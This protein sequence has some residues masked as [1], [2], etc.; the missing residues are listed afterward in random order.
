[1]I[2]KRSY[3]RTLSWLSN[4]RF[5][6]YDM[7]E[8]IEHQRL[9]KPRDTFTEVLNRFE[10]ISDIS[11]YEW[12]DL[13]HEN[14][15]FIAPV[16]PYKEDSSYSDSILTRRDD[17][18]LDRDTY[19]EYIHTSRNGDITYK[20]YKGAQILFIG[21]DYHSLAGTRLKDLYKTLT[22]A[23]PNVLFVQQKPDRFL[24][25]M[26]Y[27][28]TK[29]KKNDIFI[30]DYGKEQI[31]VEFDI[32]TYINQLVIEGHQLFASHESYN[33][34][35]RDLNKAG[36]FVQKRLKDESEE[37][38]QLRVEEM[39]EYGIMDTRER[40]SADSMTAIG[41][42]ASSHQKP[43]ILADIPDYLHRKNIAR[44][45]GVSEMRELLKEGCSDVILDPKIYPQ[46]PYFGAVHRC[47][48]IM[49]HYGDR[50]MASLL[51]SVINRNPEIGTIAVLC[52]YGQTKSIPTYMDF[53]EATLY[54]NLSVS[55]TKTHKYFGK[56]DSIHSMVEKQVILDHLYLH[57]NECA[58][59]YIQEQEKAG[60]VP[61]GVTQEPIFKT[62][63]YLINHELKESPNPVDYD[64][65][66]FKHLY[67]MLF[68]N[69]VNQLRQDSYAG[70]R[71]QLENEL[72][73]RVRDDPELIRRI[74]VAKS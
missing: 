20:T 26:K 31:K 8:V 73:R 71:K 72:K 1:M 14:K 11:E 69:E 47:P 16:K 67:L 24:D 29:T 34:V 21:P 70:A 63:R 54:D 33:R 43:I 38:Y 35:V 58:L 42:W 15:N 36:I 19:L 57:K 7:E 46:K 44:S 56:V 17:F 60:E 66:Y 52:G 65:N 6:T 30:E 64:Y 49:F 62:L 4:R 25:E 48:D 5:I 27:L 50:Y 59:D 53:S 23:K 10:D 12:L 45:E 55:D 22:L 61:N 3:G 68:A 51:K 32:E 41:L 2:V 37:A 28:P 40:I 18:R 39:K 74:Q 13:Q 9:L